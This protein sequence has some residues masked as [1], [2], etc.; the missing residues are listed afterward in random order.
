[1]NQVSHLAASAFHGGRK[2]SRPKAGA[3]WLAAGALLAG[4]AVANYLVARRSERRHPPQGRI[5]DVDGVP[6][7]VLEKGVG[8]TVVLIH[9]NGVTVQDYVLS[10]L[11]DRL[12]QHHR[13][14]AFD[15]P[16]FGYTGRPRSRS[17]TAKDQASLVL[18]ALTI[19]GVDRATVVGHSWG[20]LVALEAALQQPQRIDGLVLMSGYYWPTP[21]LDAALLSGPAIPGFGDLLRF[22]LSP[23]LGW[24]MAPLLFKQIFSPAEVPDRFKAGFQT[25]MSLR[26][27]QLR[28]TAA[29]TAMM[30]LEA[31]KTSRRH[32]EIAGPVLVMVGDG[33]KIVSFRRQSRRLARELLG[34]QLQVI[35]GAGHMIHHI[36]PDEVASGIETFVEQIGARHSSAAAA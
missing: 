22:T 24:A 8:P 29:D 18:E 7:H 4:T 19:V 33:D 23:L 31:A 5:L 30:A 21:R 17:W 15:R 16:G 14:I 12:A 25:S 6:V 13:V 11:F 10:G 34:G 36:A 9:G 32:K 26:P 3:P 28:A 1:M 2:A 35:E 20:T 27:S